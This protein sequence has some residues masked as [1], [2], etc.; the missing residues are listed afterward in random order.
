MEEFAQKIG[1]IVIA[2]SAVMSAVA[3]SQGTAPIEVFFLAVAL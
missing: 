3:L 2:A 1:I